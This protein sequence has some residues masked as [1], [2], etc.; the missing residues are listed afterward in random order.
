LVSFILLDFYLIFFLIAQILSHYFYIAICKF[1]DCNFFYFTMQFVNLSV[2]SF[3][4]TQCNYGKMLIN[5]ILDKTPIKM[6]RWFFVFLMSW[7]IIVLCFF[8]CNTVK[9][10]NTT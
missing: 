2:N 4:F 10:L 9:Y 3:L 8:R 1:I 5:A 7:L 6:P